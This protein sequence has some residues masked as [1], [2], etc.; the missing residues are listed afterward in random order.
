MR[1]SHY[2]YVVKLMERVSLPATRGSVTYGSNREFFG[3]GANENQS[4][5]SG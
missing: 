2:D 5:N 1:Q 4:P 3:N